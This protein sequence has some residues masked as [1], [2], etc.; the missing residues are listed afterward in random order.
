MTNKEKNI[1]A[2]NKNSRKILWR[3]LKYLKPYWLMTT[4][5][6]LAML[7]IN[8]VN[9]AQPQFIRRIIDNGIYGKDI[10]T[11][12]LS[13]AALLGIT[14]IKGIV[15]YFQGSWTE[16]A[17]QSVAYDLRNEIQAKLNCLSFAFHDRMETG[18]ILSRAI[19]DV[20]RI[21]FLT[22]RA[23]LRIVESLVLMVSTA[24]V[25]IW[26]NPKLGLMVMLIIPLISYSGYS[27][28]RKF[29]PLSVK[30]QNQLGKLT[31]RVEQNLLGA[32]V[33]KGFAQEDAEIKRFAQQNEIWFNQSA[34]AARMESINVPL[35][36]L[37]A[38]LGT[39]LILWYG[40]TLVLQGELSLGELV[41]FTTYLSQ[42][43]RPLRL[44]GRVIPA[45]AIAASAGERIFGI[46]DDESIIH[47]N[48]AAQPFVITSGHVCFENVSFGYEDDHPVVEDITFEAFPGQVVALLGATGS[49]KS[50]IINLITRFYDPQAGRITID[51][52]DIRDIPLR[53]LRR[54]IGIVL[55][56]TRLFAASIR[57]NIAFGKPEASEDEIVA[58]ARQAQAHDFIMEMSD[59]YDA[60]VGERGITL[61]GGQKQ[62]IAIART[63]LTDPRILIL[64]DATSSVDTQTEQLIQQALQQLME[65][66]TTFII[67][68][69]LSTVRRAELILLLENGRILAHGTHAE[70]IRSSDLYYEVYQYQLRPGER[71]ELEVV[72]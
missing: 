25:L 26:M 28:G 19:Q 4:G 29:R 3:C 45:L 48:P 9:I 44:L 61:S 31:A 14:L 46:L 1:P 72:R 39:V 5:V 60:L 2:P 42:L 43:V 63:L 58:A 68:H 40:G 62:R 55:Q 8:V 70:L 66:K 11:L 12:N 59:G 54:Q 37:I 21:R 47:D 64:D 34:L 27:Y 18:Q 57:E 16:Y 23:I 10:S 17:S 15:I 13:V 67:A 65:G 22:G 38:N 50:T 35:L 41:A 24:A 6:Y 20:E 71:A 33:V 36:D 51:G 7:V 30:I 32:Q 49:G 69:R 52:M 56:D 53:D